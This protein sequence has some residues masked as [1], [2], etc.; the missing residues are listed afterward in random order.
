MRARA[1]TLIELILVMSIIVLIAGMVAPSL[2]G[3]TAGRRVRYSATQLVSLAN[4]ARTQ[5]ISEARAYRLNFDL[6]AEKYWLTADDGTG[7][8]AALPGD[9]GEQ[10]TAPDGVKI[11]M[12]IAKQPDG[13]YIAFQPDGTVD[14][15]HIT[16]IDANGGST[17][18]ACE[19]ATENYH[20]QTGAGT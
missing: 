15:S 6:S 2:N 12:D 10:H 14:P 7:T 4:Y 9:L 19:S 8:F 13:Q 20:V 18:V 17:I 1:F 5:S 16:L 11:T 3:F